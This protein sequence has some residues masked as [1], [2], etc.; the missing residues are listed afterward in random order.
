MRQ[1]VCSLTKTKFVA[2]VK[3][4]LASAGVDSS[5]Y[6]GH[7]LSIGAA[8]MAHAQGIEDATI[9]CSADGKALCTYNWIW[10]VVVFRPVTQCVRRAVYLGYLVSD[11]LPSCFVLCTCSNTP[12]S[13]TTR[14]I[15]HVNLLIALY[16]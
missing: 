14:C 2:S 13:S 16:V 12:C 7:S 3:E 8:T 1:V 5:K 11:V 4:A 9:K 10:Q 15:T 6:A